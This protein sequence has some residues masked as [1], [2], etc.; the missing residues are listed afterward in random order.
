MLVQIKI[1]FFQTQELGIGYGGSTRFDFVSLLFF[2]GK[3]NQ[4]LLISLKV[5]FF[6]LQSKELFL[7][8]K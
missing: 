5:I 1:I 4:R 8:Y 7:L 3:K 2:V 6:I